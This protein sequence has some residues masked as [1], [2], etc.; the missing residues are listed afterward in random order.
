MSSVK[1]EYAYQKDELLLAASENVSVMLPDSVEQSSIVVTVDKPESVQAPI[2]KGEVIGT[3]TLSYANEVIATVPVVA[4]E[5]VSRSDLI[6][7]WEQ[8]RKLLSSP[9]FVAIMA[10]IGALVV[11]YLILVVFYRRKQKQLKRVKKFRDM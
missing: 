9:W 1:L 7:G 4:T 11:V 10:T 6:A 5:S 2:R 3:A 8:G